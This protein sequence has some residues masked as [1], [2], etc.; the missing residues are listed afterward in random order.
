MAHRKA[1][2]STNNNRDSR[3]KYLGVKRFGG[4]VVRTGEI[5]IRQ[6]GSKFRAG[7]NTK[8]TKDDTIISLKDGIVAFATKRIQ[9]FTGKIRKVKFIEIEESK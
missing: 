3:P 6:R 2:G 9:L 5:L 4:Q 7:K 1:G 8:Q